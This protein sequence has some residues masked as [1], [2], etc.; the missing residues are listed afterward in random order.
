MLSLQFR[1]HLAVGA[2]LLAIVV[3]DASQNGLAQLNVSE[4]SA[5]EH[6]LA[7]L[8]TGFVPY[9]VAASAFKALAPAA[10][11]L[12][13][14]S[15]ISWARAHVGSPAFTSAYA[16]LRERSKPAG[17]DAKGSVDDEL[18]AQIDEQLKQVAEMRKTIPTLPAEMRAGMEEAVKQIEAMGKDPDMLSM[19]RTGIEMGRAQAKTQHEADVQRWNSSFPAIR[20]CCLPGGSGSSWTSPRT[21]ISTRRSSTAAARKC[22]PSRAMNRSRLTG[23]C[24]S[25]P[26][27]RR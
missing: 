1:S 22:L 23:R 4:S 10:R 18:K 7:S 5:Q 19:L 2:A 15:A 17:P 24:V 12:V 11:G 20:R 16:V 9:H 21:S 25:A 6:A 3:V 14:D 8:T 13:V 26:V 27:R